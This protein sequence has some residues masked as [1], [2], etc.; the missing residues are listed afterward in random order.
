MS[1]KKAL[2][3]VEGYRRPRF[4]WA[5]LIKSIFTLGFSNAQAA[6]ESA[7]LYVFE[8]YENDE[9]VIYA[10]TMTGQKKEVEHLY[11]SAHDFERLVTEKKK[12]I[13]DR[14]VYKFDID[15]FKKSK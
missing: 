11:V 1:K 7:A 6:T 15:T 4:I 10:E 13:D 12:Y 9:A 14:Y 2:M 5:D 8:F 3:K